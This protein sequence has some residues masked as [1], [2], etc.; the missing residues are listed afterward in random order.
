MPTCDWL[1][2]ARDIVPD[3]QGDGVAILGVAGSLIVDR[4]PGQVPQGFA[5]RISGAPLTHCS[6]QLSIDAPDQSRVFT[7]A[8]DQF[9][10]PVS[11]F[12]DG[13]F[14]LS[15]H[16]NVP[17]LYKVTALIDG[18]PM[19]TITWPVVVQQVM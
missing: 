16:L 17:G 19:R 12:I 3:P 13:H 1:I 14:P 8:N 9:T 2:P 11:G 4:L 18:E 15:L 10:I 7:T 5:F 6:I